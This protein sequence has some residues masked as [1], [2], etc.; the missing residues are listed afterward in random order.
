MVPIEKY[1]KDDVDPNKEIL[2]QTT[3]V[4]LNIMYIG[5]LVPILDMSTLT[6]SR[7]H[8]NSPNLF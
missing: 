7:R 5:N 4:S 8:S 3:T 1:M 2:M 6:A